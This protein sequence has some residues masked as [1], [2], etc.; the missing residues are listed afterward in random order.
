MIEFSS[1]HDQMD[2]LEPFRLML[3]AASEEE[4]FQWVRV[5]HESVTSGSSTKVNGC[6]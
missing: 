4:I 6:S 3:Q 2:P 1:V 5:D